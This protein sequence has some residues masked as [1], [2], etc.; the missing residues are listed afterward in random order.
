MVDSTRQENIKKV[1]RNL[2][3]VPT[4]PT[5]CGK[6]S[7]L[8]SN[9]KTTSRDLGNVI[10]EDQ[11]LTTKILRVVNSAFY[12][13]PKKVA[14]LGRA[15]V[16]LGFNEMRNIVYSISVIKLFGK[17]KENQFFDHD[18]FWKHAVGVGVCS[19]IIAL[20]MENQFQKI[21][22][23]AFVG[24]LIHDV[25]KIVEDQFMHDEFSVMIQACRKKNLSMLAAEN[26]VLGFNHQDI[27]FLLAK[28]WNLPDTVANVLRY[29]NR[30][31]TKTCPEDALPIVSIVHIADILVRALQ[32]GSGGDPFVPE[33]NQECWDFLGLK[34]SQIE[35]IMD[36]TQS[37]Y[38]EMAGLMSE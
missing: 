17:G 18:E 9:P 12:G 13:F 35:I 11:A 36:E 31:R 16:V 27:G 14:S 6:I 19:R 3:Q 5:V 25:G 2:D 32:I 24:G 4:L 29:H 26:T 34:K 8:M 1:I 28:K 20:N 23:E 21:A 37:H 30:V 15:V 33:L 7:S 10:R 22:E 38:K